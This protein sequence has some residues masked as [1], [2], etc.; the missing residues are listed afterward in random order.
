MYYIALFVWYVG[1]SAMLDVQM[2]WEN[3]KESCLPENFC[4]INPNH[5]LSFLLKEN[6]VIC[7]LEALS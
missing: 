7:N 5:V 3:Q 6:G 2:R 1:F 4:F